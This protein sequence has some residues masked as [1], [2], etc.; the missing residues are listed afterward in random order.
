MAAP[1]KLSRQQPSGETPGVAAAPLALADAIEPGI[2]RFIVVLSAHAGLFGVGI[3]AAAGSMLVPP[4]CATS[5]GIVPG[6]GF[7][8]IS[9]VESGK[10]APLV[11]GPPGVVPH[12]VAEGLPS[13][14]TGDMV[15]VVL[16]L[17]D[18]ELIVDGPNDIAVVALV[19]AVDATVVPGA[20]L[21]PGVVTMVPGGS[22]VPC[23]RIT[24]V[25]CGRAVP[26]GTSSPGVPNADWLLAPF[27]VGLAVTGPDEAIWVGD[28]KVVCAD[29][30]EQLMLVPGAVGSSASG[31]GASV[32]SG[33]PGWVKAENGLGPLSGEV[34]IAPGVDGR[35]MAVL[36][37]VESCARQA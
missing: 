14:A 5:C 1:Q 33:V 4:S 31:T 25:P 21:V 17:I 36:P 29:T 34:T 35:P 3:T 12:T 24:T 11:G 27:D 18:V 15:P 20:T 7:A 9:G 22:I 30:G 28:V 37:R 2:A 6:G 26:S 10:A 13:G 16:P 23:G 19:L 8:G 32:V